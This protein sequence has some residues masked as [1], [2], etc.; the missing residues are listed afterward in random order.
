[1]LKNRVANEI[2]RNFNSGSYWNSEILAYFD[3]LKIATLQRLRNWHTGTMSHPHVAKLILKIIDTRKFLMLPIYPLKYWILF[4]PR[5]NISRILMRS[6]VIGLTYTWSWLNVRLIF[7][8]Y[9]VKI[10]HSK[11]SK[12]CCFTGRISRYY[13]LFNSKY[14]VIMSLYCK[15][16]DNFTTWLNTELIY[17]IFASFGNNL[18]VPLCFHLC[19]IYFAVRL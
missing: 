18:D 7:G 9:I 15:I 8:A 19:D 16:Y 4:W 5:L 6:N 13:F 2:S 11:S 14:S 12:E 17:M 1:M 10:A 3:R